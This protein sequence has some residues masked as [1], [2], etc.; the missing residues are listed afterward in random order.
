[1][2]AILSTLE[3]VI[4]LSSIV[5]GL[6]LSIVLSVLAIG[7]KATVADAT[8]VIRHPR[9]FARALV[10]MYVVAPV[11][12]VALAWTFALPPAVKI[13]MV[14]LSVSPVPPIL[15]NMVVKAGGQES[16]AIGLLVATAVLAIV[17]VPL[18]MA[19]LATAFGL[20][21]RMSALDVARLVALTVL[22]PLAVGIAIRA[23]LPAFSE[24]VAQPLSWIGGG[25]L[26]L[27]ALLM[28]ALSWRGALSLVGN[29]TLAMAAVV[30][31]VALAAG[32]ALGGPRADDRTVLALSAAS[33]HPG[34]ALA[35]AHVNFPDER[36]A[37]PAVLLFLI[38]N[39][40]VSIP[41][42][43]WTNRQRRAGA[44]ITP[45]RAG[46]STV[47]RRD[48]ERWVR[49]SIRGRV[50]MFG[51]LNHEQP[52]KVVKRRES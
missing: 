38:V 7:L 48:Q 44:A 1:M 51:D 6:K 27:S 22:A 25:L 13:A 43:T 52:I 50:C 34:V 23:I 29:G 37:L 2:L 4:V 40:L 31:A 18:A 19:V 21:M 3:E 49:P 28:L 42:V 17:I 9:P 46:P 16:L 24:A 8:F 12:A 11:V 47:R 30:T 45:A 35:I 10:A 5:L 39:A 32:H 15:P 26:L 20:P 41:Y 14:A 33:R 36:L